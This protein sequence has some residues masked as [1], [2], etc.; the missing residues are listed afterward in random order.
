MRNDI[1]WPMIALVALTLVVW[2]RM[3]FQ[4]I[5]E[6]KAMRIHPQAIATS[7]AASEKLRNTGAADNF[8]NLFEVP[9]LF[10]AICL[11]LAL[12]D[13]VTATQLALAWAFV[14]LRVAHSAIQATY[15]KVRH[16]FYVYALGAT[17]VYVMWAI[18]A[19][20]LARG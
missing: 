12:T 4:R 17:C 5:G 19:V 11:A 16:R 7:A 6:M 13:R 8:R 10:Y 9:V 2:L 3:Y 1:Y 18:F 14:A 20:S 15:N